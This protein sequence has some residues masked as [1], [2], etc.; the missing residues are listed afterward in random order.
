VEAVRNDSARLKAL[1]PEFHSMKDAPIQQYVDLYT[2]TEGLL[3]QWKATSKAC[4]K[5]IREFRAGDG[6]GGK[7]A[8]KKKKDGSDD[9]E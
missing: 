1:L 7:K 5:R 3:S 4:E 9:D 2:K 6:K 8:R